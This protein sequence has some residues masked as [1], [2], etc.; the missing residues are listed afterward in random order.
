MFNTQLFL[1]LDRVLLLDFVMDGHLEERVCLVASELF[2]VLMPEIEVYGFF[3][4][5]GARDECKR[6]SLEV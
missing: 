3:V 6:D 4:V 5:G 2:K 1:L